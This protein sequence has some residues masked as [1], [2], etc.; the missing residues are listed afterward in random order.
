[1]YCHL[2]SYSYTKGQ[3]ISEWIYELIV[4]SKIRTKNC[5]DFCPD[6]QGRNP[7]NF[8]FDFWKKR[9]VYKFILKLTDLYPPPLV[10]VVCERPLSRAGTLI[11][12]S[13][14]RCGRFA[15]SE[16]SRPNGRPNGYEVF[17]SGI[18]KIRN[19]LSWNIY[20]RFLRI[21]NEIEIN[22]SNNWQS[23]FDV[24]EMSIQISSLSKSC[25][26]V[27]TIQWL[28]SF[29]NWFNSFLVKAALQSLHLK[30]RTLWEQI[31]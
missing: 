9:W 14:G 28:C 31:Y 16:L 6:S 3:L 20:L 8:S 30:I 27:T 22:V 2:K 10:N 17:D 25:F 21:C 12:R 11:V 23:I 26:A 4:S 1:M 5:K 24:V 15:Y 29:V 18:Q 7:C 13:R 19:F